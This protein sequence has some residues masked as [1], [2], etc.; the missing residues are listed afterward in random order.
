MTELQTLSMILWL[1]IAFLYYHKIVDGYGHVSF[2]SPSKPDR[3]YMTAAVSPGRVVADDVVEFDLDGQ[4]SVA[5]NG[6]LI[7]SASS[8]ARFIGCGPMSM[9]SSTAIR[10]RSSH[11]ASPGLHSGRSSTPQ[12]FFIRALRSLIQVAF[13]PRRPRS[14][15][16]RPSG[17]PLPR[18]SLRMLSFS[19]AGTETRLLRV[20]SARL[21]RARLYGG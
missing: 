17:K 19:C 6:R 11:L 10:R 4:S 1:R 14:S 12:R 21:W 9:R 3:F 13:P 15:T 8:I 2:R 5:T 16:I 20:T 7:P 18:R